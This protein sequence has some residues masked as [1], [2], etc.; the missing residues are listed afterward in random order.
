MNNNNTLPPIR[1]TP[2]IMSKKYFYPILLH[3]SSLTTFSA[4]TLSRFPPSNAF[5][6]NAQ[7]NPHYPFL[8]P[9]FC[10][11]F[12]P[13]HLSILSIPFSSDKIMGDSDLISVSKALSSLKSLY[14]L[15]INLTEFLSNFTS[16]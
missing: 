4:K 15:Q 2:L 11:F 13:F 5:K 6:R 9:S 1:K 14:D 12:P 10:T 8:T 7:S 3:S 16:S